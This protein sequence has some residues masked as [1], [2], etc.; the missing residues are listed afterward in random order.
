MLCGQAGQELLSLLV[1]KHTKAEFEVQFHETASTA[2]C[3]NS[4]MCWLLSLSLS[5]GQPF[6]RHDNL[7]YIFLTLYF[8]LISNDV[9]CGKLLRSAGITI[10]GHVFGS[11]E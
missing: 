3:T 2:F 9:Y 4:H 7:A 11:P 8:D 6:S 10:Y 5:K 1:H